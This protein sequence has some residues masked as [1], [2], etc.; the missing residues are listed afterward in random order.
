[1]SVCLYSCR[2]YPACKAHPFNAALY[3]RVWP[4]WLYHVF[5]LYLINSTI[6][7]KEKVT[8]RKVWVLIFSTTFA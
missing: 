3:C 1:M 5:P 2:S 6:F 4:V 7:G 8:E